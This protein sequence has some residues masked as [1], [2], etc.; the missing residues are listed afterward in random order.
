MFPNGARVLKGV[1][2]GCRGVGLGVAKGR[3][4]MG[5]FSSLAAEVVGWIEDRRLADESDCCRMLVN[6]SSMLLSS[7][8]LLTSSTL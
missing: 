6:Q 7:L 8:E 1:E 2:R 3:T 4:V 5:T